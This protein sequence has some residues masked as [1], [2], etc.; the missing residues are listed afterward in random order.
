MNALRPIMGQFDMY[1]GKDLADNKWH[2]VEYIR[3]IRQ[4]I[5]YI[6][7]SM[8][9]GERFVFRKSPETYDELS[10]S[11]VTFGGFYSFS[12][13]DLPSQMSLSRKG[14]QACFSEA[15]FSQEWYPK[16]ERSSSPYPKVINF[17]EET[18]PDQN[19][20]PNV[21]NIEEMKDVGEVKT[22]LTCTDTIPSYR[23]LFFKSSVVHLG[24]LQNYTI[25]SL[26]M[27]M[28][29]RTV[30]NEQTLANFTHL[31]SGESVELRINRKGRVTLQLDQDSKVKIIETAK[32][33]FHDN[34]WHSVKFEI[35]N[36]ETTDKSYIASFTVDGKTRYTQLNQKIK[37]DG[38]INLGFGFTGCMRDIKINDD[39]INRVRRSL[40][41]NQEQYFNVSDVGVV[42]DYCSVRDFCN[43]NPCQ[44]SGKCN[45]TDDN[46]ICN[47]EGTL[48]EGST[49]HRR[50][51]GFIRTCEHIKTYLLIF[52]PLL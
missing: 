2:T 14:I 34:E 48:Y 15:T 51:H 1:A 9:R 25:Q 41:E 10:V 37:F 30:V 6:D 32:E 27:E 45:Q 42:Y 3:N 12:T 17:M 26:K 22:V 16:S 46:F 4:N 20:D 29:F 39:E 43:P 40:T 19:T 11:M 18:L 21:K 49:C 36:Q 5:I 24:L 8:G 33:D 23:P 50:K 38:Y 47:C 31:D 35:D 13:S 28:K 7:R 44:N 52:F